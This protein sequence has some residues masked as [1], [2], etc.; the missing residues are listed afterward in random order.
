MRISQVLGL[1]KKFPKV[2]YGGKIYYGLKNKP[3]G[4]QNFSIG[5]HAVVL[6]FVVKMCVVLLLRS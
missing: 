1:V 4:G 6:H 3:T 2:L 5:F